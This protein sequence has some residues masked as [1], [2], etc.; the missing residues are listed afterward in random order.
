MIGDARSSGEVAVTSRRL[1][2]VA[3]ALPVLPLAYF[4]SGYVASGSGRVLAG[5]GIAAAFVGLSWLIRGFVT[6]AVV[7]TPR[8]LELRRRWRSVIVPRETIHRL[9]GS[10]TQRPEWSTQVYADT[11]DGRVTIPTFWRPPVTEVV[12]QL[13]AWH[14]ATAVDAPARD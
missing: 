5:V 7:V 6:H 3:E 14:A 9:R 4:G 12:T 10:N 13:Q 1:F 2:G 8:A 11:E